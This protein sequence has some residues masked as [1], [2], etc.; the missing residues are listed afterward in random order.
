MLRPEPEKVAVLGAGGGMDVE[1]A[2]LSGAKSVDAVEIDP[3][4]IKL[5]KRFSASRVYYDDRVT[6]HIDDARAFLQQTS[7]NYD[8]IVFGF[9][10]SQALFS[11]MSNIRL[12]GFVYTVES[13]RTAYNRLSDNGMLAISFYIAKKR[14]L[15][16]KLIE[17][18]R[19]ATGKNPVSYFDGDKL[20]VCAYRSD[21][22]PTPPENINKFRLI[23]M[24]Y[25]GTSVATDDWPYLYLSK[26]T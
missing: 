24:T 8:L 25:M 16:D 12:D 11:A 4:L 19:E 7:V 3:A 13:M 2:I 1:A 21:K 10:D 9:L 5:S 15:A 17:M 26:K 6:V 20:I 18:V 23:N 22:P 14:W